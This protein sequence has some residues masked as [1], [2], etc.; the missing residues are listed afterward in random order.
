MPHSLHYAYTH[1]ATES[2]TGYFSCIPEPDLPLSAALCQL[3]IGPMDEFLHRHIL[4]QCL[5]MSP[6]ALSTAVHTVKNSSP[7]HTKQELAVLTCLLLECAI[8]NPTLCSFTENCGPEDIQASLAL[9]PLPYLRW[10]TIP[11]KELHRTW[12]RIF[13]ANITQHSKLPHPHELEEENLSHLYTQKSLPTPTLLAVKKH[14]IAALHSEYKAT[15]SSAWS[16]P[17]AQETA[18][19]ALSV[20]MENAIIDGIEMRHENS[21]SPIALL[22][23]WNISVTVHSDAVQYTL[24][25]QA[26]TYGRGL[27]LA[28]ARASYAMEMIE[29]ASSYTSVQ[30]NQIMGLTRPCPLFKARFS[31]LQSQGQLAL[32]P[33]TLPLEIPYND[34]AI[35]WIEAEEAHSKKTVLVP[36]QCVFLFCNL[37]EAALFLNAGSTGLASGNTLAE[38]KLSALTEILERD[39]EAV[40]PYDFRR[41]FQLRAH[42]VKLQA[43]LDD[44]TARGIHVHFLDLTTEFGVPCYQ[45]FVM[46]R[47][48]EIF[49]ATG[50]GLHGQRAAI[51][52]LTEVPYP[53]PHGAPSAPPLKG[54]AQKFLEDLPN[55]SLESPTRNVAFLEDILLK[56]GYKPLY[57]EIS[58]EDLELPVVRAIIPGL[59]ISAELDNFS[60][61]SSRLYANYMHMFT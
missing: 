38:A 35:Y 3:A 17:P 37:D 60:R 14:D 22:R 15:P 59:E 8:L 21:L 55:Y 28:D 49:R 36:A 31:E 6:D 7:P 48:G 33:N 19:H 40:M 57:V 29:R 56:H 25:G 43:L 61:V 50:A 27:S 39:A 52:A 9:T 23:P 11:D 34:T 4:R 46:G 42:D 24:Q 45:A 44:Y 2:T 41:C 1:T 5:A 30:N 54:L 16:R 10:E 32:N 12:S 18:R 53:Y 47:K 58:R 26:T 20:L 51:A 13:T